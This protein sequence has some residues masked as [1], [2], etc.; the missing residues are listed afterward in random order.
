YHRPGGE[1]PAQVQL[2]QSQEGRRDRRSSQAIDSACPPAARRA[3]QASGE[4]PCASSRRRRPIP[5]FLVLRLPCVTL[6]EVPLPCGSISSKPW[7]V[8]ANSNSSFPTRP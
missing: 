5:G 3:G 6:E 4:I 1:V 2:G 8:T 7:P